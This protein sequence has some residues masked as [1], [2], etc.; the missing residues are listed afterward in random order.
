MNILF[1]QKPSSS[2]EFV[3]LTDADLDLLH[4][5]GPVEATE[6]PVIPR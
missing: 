3:V 1:T 4:G 2:S 6:I 5:G